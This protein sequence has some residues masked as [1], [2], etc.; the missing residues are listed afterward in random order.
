VH[1]RPVRNSVSAPVVGDTQVDLA[2][3][4][5]AGPQ[6]LQCLINLLQ[7]C[8]GPDLVAECWNI[9]IPRTVKIVRQHVEPIDERLDGF[10]VHGLQVLVLGRKGNGYAVVI[11]QP[12]PKFRHESDQVLSVDRRVATPALRA[13]PLPVDVDTTELPFGEKLAKRFDERMPVFL[14]AGHLRPSPSSRSWVAELP[15]TDA[16]VLR[17]TVWPSHEI[18]IYSFLVGMHLEDLVCL[19]VDR[20]KGEN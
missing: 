3:I 12:L 20:G 15:A 10:R 16:K 14:C 13:W 6:Q 7:V 19:R 4:D 18:V 8:V 1:A 5:V 2:R 17:D 11:A 9:G